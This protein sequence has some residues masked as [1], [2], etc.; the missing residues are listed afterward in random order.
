MRTMSGRRVARSYRLPS[1]S[2]GRLPELRI[3]REELLRAADAAEGVAA[4]RDEAGA[5][6]RAR[7]GGEGGREQHHLV[8]RAAHR[9]DARRLVDGG[10]DDGEV[11]PVLAADVAVEDLADMEPEIDMRR[12]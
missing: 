9:G 1:K 6:L 5:V 12:R 10:A 11:E 2:F 3:D 4:D 8:G 7:G